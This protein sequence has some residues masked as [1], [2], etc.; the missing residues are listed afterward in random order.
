M[1]GLEP[2]A[3]IHQAKRQVQL[4]DH[5]RM[6]EMRLFLQNRFERL[7]W[8]FYVILT[9]TGRARLT[10]IGAIFHG[11]DASLNTT[12]GIATKNRAPLNAQNAG[13][14]WPLLVPMAG[15][16]GAIQQDAF[17]KI[18]QETAN[19]KNEIVHC[20]VTTEHPIKEMADI[21]GVEENLKNEHKLDSVVVTN[22]IE[23]DDRKLHYKPP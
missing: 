12:T 7:I 5:G 16:A 3:R 21:Q 13:S 18:D 1:P 11:G 23:L 6:P 2:Q 4:L 14:L 19:M 20:Q 9:I 22:F 8:I 10:A 17:N 15:V